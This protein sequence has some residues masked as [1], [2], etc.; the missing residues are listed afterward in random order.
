MKKTTVCH[1][2]RSAYDVYIGRGPDPLTGV[3]GKWGNPFH[4][5]K[6]GTR[7]EVLAKH[8]EWVV[9]QP[10][11]MAAIGELKG[12]RLG[13][14]CRPARCHGDTLAELADASGE[15]PYTQNDEALFG[16]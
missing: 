10:E 16:C 4:I 8:R 13:C 14:W 7:A 5:G 6:D 15:A 11:L 2:K 9:R 1:C 12:K 3:E